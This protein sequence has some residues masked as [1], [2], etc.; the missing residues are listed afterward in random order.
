MATSELKGVLLDIDGTLLDSNDAHAASFTRAFAEHGLDIPFDHVRPLVGMGSDKL[1]P[2]LTGFA[3]DTPEGKA[4]VERKK[5]IFE[6]RYLSQLKPTPGARALLTRWLAQDL[7]L[8]VA[9]SAG[10]DEMK[11][12][13]K[14]AGIEDLIDDATS[15]GDVDNS[16][17]DPDVIGAA[18]KK[19]KLKAGELVMLGDTPYDVE[20]ARKAGVATIALRC[21]GW[22]NDD[23]F[24]DAIAIYDDPADLLANWS[25]AMTTGS[26]RPR[27]RR[28]SYR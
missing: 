10:G 19:S 13:L 7:T 6:E 14:Q 21:G 1:I 25:N 27:P 16:K 3:H 11:G 5:G 20:A 23:A 2:S 17:P 4:I 18:I 12:L 9:T 8:V 28:P 15:S 22:W 26:G 24:E